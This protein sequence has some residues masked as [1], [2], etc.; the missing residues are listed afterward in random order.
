MRS[1]LSHCRDLPEQ[2]IAAGE[3]LLEEGGPAGVLYIL[4]EGTV[5]ILKGGYQIRTAQE[6]GSLFGEVSVLLGGAHTATVKT[7]S[8]CRVYRVEL[9]VEFLRSH[10]EVTYGVATLL[11]QRLDSITGYLVDLKRQFEGSDEH[12]GMVDEVLEALVH[13]QDEELDLGSEREPD[14]T[15]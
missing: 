10:T 3:I 12:F 11:A 6:P 15:I 4:I 2:R 1:I 7:I 9:A 13:Q 14:T 8:E 5:E